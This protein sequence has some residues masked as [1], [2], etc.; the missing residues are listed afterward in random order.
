VSRTVV[1]D[2]ARRYPPTRAIVITASAEIRAKRLG[3]R[4][5]EGSE[6]ISSRLARAADVPAGVASETIVNDGAAAEGIARLVALLR[7]A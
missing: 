4:G 2:A 7:S 5:R 3:A 1:A 6:G